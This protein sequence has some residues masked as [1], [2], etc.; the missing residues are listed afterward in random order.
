MKGF[1]LVFFFFV[2][3]CSNLTFAQSEKHPIIWITEEEREQVIANTEKYDWAKSILGQLHEHVDALMIS[4]KSNPEEILKSIPAF[5][6][7]LNEHNRIL[8]LAAEAGMLYYLSKNENYA[9]LSADIIAAYTYPLALKTPQTT[10]IM[11]DAFHDPRTCYNML[12]LAYDFTYTFLNKNQTYIYNLNTRQSQPF[13]N[14]IAQQAFKNIVGNILQEYGE[15]D[16]HGQFISNHPVLTAPGALYSILCIDDSV[17]RERLFNVFWEKG[18]KHQ[19]SFKHTI[20]PMFSGQGIWPESL[21]YSFMPNISLVLNIVDRIKPEMNITKDY[22]HIFNGN[23]LFTNLRHPDRRFVR[24]GDSKRNNDFTEA[25]YRYA[26]HIA[27][28]R[29]YNALAKESMEA[30][31]KNYDAKGGRKPNMSNSTYDNSNFLELFWGVPMPE[32]NVGEISYKPTVI[33]EHAGVALQRNY[34]KE[35]NELYGLCGIIGGAHY[36][37]SHLTGISMELYGAGYVMAPNAGLPA[38]V[39]ERQIPLH[40]HY[41]RIYA[42]NNTVVVNG[43]SHGRDEG[44]WKGKAN[45]WQNKAINIAAEPKH[46]EDPI[47]EKFSF[48]T[49]YLKDEINYADQER[50]LSVIRT[51][52]TTA[53][54]FDMFRS[55]SLG[56]NKF[57][58]YLY[59]NIGDA[60]HLADLKEKELALT[61]TDR[62]QNDIGDVVHAPGWRY[63]EETKTTEPVSD[64]IK[65]RFDIKYDNR[66]MHM[67]IPGDVSRAYTTALAPP[68]REAING[69]VN[70]KTQVLAIRQNGEAWDRPFVSVFEPSLN[71]KSSIE[72]VEHLK[73]GTKIVG[74]KVVTRLGEK[75]I[76]DYIISQDDSKAIYKNSKLKL[77]FTG[78]FAIVRNEKYKGK[79]STQLYIGEGENL[80]FKKYKLKSDASK[81]AFQVFGN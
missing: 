46:L 49:Q 20:L 32:T 60:L 25:N 57:H 35:H 7:N 53:Y 28:R 29:G 37:H 34:V 13:Q 24:F 26:L 30:L 23:F 72:A 77:A 73:S 68:T 3:F 47:A 71:P 58:D 48:A 40:E 21:S 67:F 79:E 69:Y 12:A 63:F 22:Q 19:P 36:V 9:Q 61:E 10:Q 62:Y 14:E 1:Q 4:H 56:E 15:S 80:K 17:E 55:K 42:G 27:S 74:L 70:K 81:K 64:A 59:H 8:T 65:V 54:Y 39:E 33:V 76:T 75:N 44:S 5:G 38:S 2:L 18:T 6:G 45:V 52:D 66:Y 31:K 50:T 11:G 41:Y 16:K 78:R 43:A 51:S